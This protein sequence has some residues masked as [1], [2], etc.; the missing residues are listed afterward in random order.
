M[1]LEMAGNIRV[2]MLVFHKKGKEGLQSASNILSSLLRELYAVDGRVGMFFL[3]AVGSSCGYLDAVSDMHNTLLRLH[4]SP[5]PCYIKIYYV[6]CVLLVMDFSSLL[7]L[8][9]LKYVLPGL[10]SCNYC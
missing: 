10:Y 9:S 7:S 8:F 6:C 1:I 4:L 2:V 5:V 3:L